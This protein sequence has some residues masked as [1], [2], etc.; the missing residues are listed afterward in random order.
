MAVVTSASEMLI[1]CTL[2]L[3]QFSIHE[4]IIL[5]NAEHASIVRKVKHT[6]LGLRGSCGSNEHG[7]S[8]GCRMMASSESRS[9]GSFTST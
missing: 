5:M 6:W 9:R 7:A 1:S 8:Q 3:H 2:A 4:G